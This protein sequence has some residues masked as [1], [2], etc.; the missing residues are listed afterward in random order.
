MAIETNLLQTIAQRSHGLSERFPAV[1]LGPGDD[2]A[3][4]DPQG[5]VLLT[6]D[7][8]VAGRH[9]PEW[10]DGGV[11]DALIDLTAR[12]AVA[13]S[14]SDIA[15]MAGTP[16]A[17]LATACLPAWV[18]QP[19]ANALFERMK[20]WAERWHAPIVGGDIATLGRTQ[21]GPLVLTCTVLGA[22]HP[23]RGAVL[24][25]GAKPGDGVYVTG[26]LGGSLK[27]GRHASFEPRVE[28]AASLADALGARLTAM[29]DLSDGLG[30]DGSRLARASNVTLELDERAIPRHAD[31][32]G[33]LAPI[34]DG[35]D[36][37]LLFT[38]RSEPPASLPGGAD[39]LPVT[40][41]GTVI[42][43][44]ADPGCLLVQADGSRRDISTL[45]WDHGGA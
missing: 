14:I 22:P 5:P 18:S 29:M 6:V 39:A 21:T 37:E 30:L 25:S 4:V 17:S 32:Q 1:L 24:R 15:A 35:E 10:T 28:A 36:Y 20:F 26:A 3:L 41:I 19:V 13:R 9:V 12:K 38:A 23:R 16:I 27:S 34:R 7:H 11:T 44:S 40:R 42:A 2:C 31:A 8:V 33:P 45:G 43:P